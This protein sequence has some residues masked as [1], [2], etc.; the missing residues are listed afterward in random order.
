MLFKF[1]QNIS[2]WL[3]IRTTYVHTAHSYTLECTPIIRYQNKPAEQNHYYTI[4]GGSRN[5][6]QYSYKI[7]NLY[8]EILSKLKWY[9]W[10]IRCGEKFQYMYVNNYVY[11]HNYNITSIC[12]IGYEHKRLHAI[13]SV[14]AFNTQRLLED[15]NIRLLSAKPVACRQMG[16]T[17]DIWYIK[18]LYSVDCPIHEPNLHGTSPLSTSTIK[19]LSIILFAWILTCTQPGGDTL[20]HGDSLGAW[21]LPSKVFMPWSEYL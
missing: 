10:W 14:S 13:C 3:L 15:M 9:I 5:P 18:I 1:E 7:I 17:F 8:L 2:F 19:T 12:R 16:L 20:N 11:E 4:R 6:S 21:P